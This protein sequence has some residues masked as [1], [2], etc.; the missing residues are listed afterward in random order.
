MVDK[1]HLQIREIKNYAK[2]E[3][4]PIMHDEGINYLTNFVI[5]HKVQTVL[6]IGTAI[7][8]SAIMMALVSPNLKIIS[9][10][11]DEERYLEA[12]KNIKKFDLEDRITLVFSD[13][14]TTGIKEKFD[15]IFIDAAKGQNINFFNYFEGN[16][17]SSG[18]I[19]TDNM[20]F[21]GYVE[22]PEED[23]SNKNL[24][25]LVCK[26]KNYRCFLEEHDDYNTEFL[27]IGDGLAVSSKK[28]V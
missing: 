21:H 22:I 25:S 4:I 28:E 24:R 16:L 1:T 9:I 17:N 2:V 7:G 6:E 19:I 8:Y 27:D 14:L 20:N 15:L 11:R 12:L 23:I 26:I 13:A 18:H 10:E 5:K 3:N